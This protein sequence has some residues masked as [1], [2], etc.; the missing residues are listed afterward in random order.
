VR[1]ALLATL[2]LLLPLAA[3]ARDERDEV[4]RGVLRAMGWGI[5]YGVE[6]EGLGP[7][8]AP[9]CGDPQDLRE[10]LRDARAPWRAGYPHRVR[11]EPAPCRPSPL[12]G[13]R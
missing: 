2:A 13:P 6:P 12:D 9:V 5:A 10:P 7:A 1:F 11:S 8:F 3:G 4:R